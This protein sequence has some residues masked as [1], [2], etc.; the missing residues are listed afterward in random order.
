[1]GDEA[2]DLLAGGFAESLG[3]AKIDRVGLE[4]VWI[5]L[6]LT[7][8]LA[9]TVAD[10]GST[11]VAILPID[12]LGRHLLRL[13]GGWSGFGK[14]ADLLDRADADAVGL[15]QGPVDSP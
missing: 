9:E 6:M 8:Q 7:D 13:P 1:M 11:V 12:R 4:E 10:L 5:E 14:R 2:F 15:A 3:A